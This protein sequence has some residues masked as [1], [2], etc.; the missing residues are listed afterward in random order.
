MQ[1]VFED[2]IS[3]NYW[4][5]C[6]EL[7]VYLQWVNWKEQN[8]P[9]SRRMAMCDKRSEIQPV[10]PKDFWCLMAVQFVGKVLLAFEEHEEHNKVIYSK[11]RSLARLVV[12]PASIRAVERIYPR[13]R[14]RGNESTN[15]LYA[16]YNGKWSRKEIMTS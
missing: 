4:R 6:L 10:D 15:Y 2:I 7:G 14:S 9:M 16:Q 13:I 5:D 11:D 1:P 3:L 8:S 12:E